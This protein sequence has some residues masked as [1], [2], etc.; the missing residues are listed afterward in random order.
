M[1]S[2]FDSINQLLGF[3][4]IDLHAYH[5]A[6]HLLTNL[7]L[8]GRFLETNHSEHFSVANYISTPEVIIFSN[9]P[10]ATV[11]PWAFLQAMDYAIQYTSETDLHVKAE[12]AVTPSNAAK[13]NKR[14][15]T[16]DDV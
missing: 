3:V 10:L 5:C 13:R 14:K 12:A 8:P 16:I 1:G 4:K 7:S 11:L 2:I 6:Y 9:L 15:R